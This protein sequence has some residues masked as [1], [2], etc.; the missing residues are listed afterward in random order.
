MPRPAQSSAVPFAAPFAAPVAA[1]RSPGAFDWVIPAATLLFAALAAAT[2]ALSLGSPQG[3]AP[4]A[5]PPGL[6]H[7]LHPLGTTT[8]A[9]ERCDATTGACRILP[10]EEVAWRMSDGSEWTART[11]FDDGGRLAYTLWYDPGGVPVPGLPL[12]D[13]SGQGLPGAGSPDL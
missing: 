3:S 2:A 1:Q 11:A 9:V 10:V 7:P 5:Q 13:L 12:P 6:P 8:A 4:A